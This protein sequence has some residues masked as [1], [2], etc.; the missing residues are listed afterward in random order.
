MSNVIVYF[1]DGTNKLFEEHEVSGG[2]YSNMVTYDNGFVIIE[3]PYGNKTSYF[4]D[5]I[6]HV[7]QETSRRSW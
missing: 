4:G 3:D 7:Y 1:K 2:S 6:N 5:H